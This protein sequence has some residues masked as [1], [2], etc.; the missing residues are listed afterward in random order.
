M[1]LFEPDACLMLCPVGMFIVIK[2][3][4]DFY[5]SKL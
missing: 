5:L 1:F 3:I 2:I 4:P